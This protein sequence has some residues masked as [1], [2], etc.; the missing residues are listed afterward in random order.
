MFYADDYE[1]QTYTK[2]EIIANLKT[3]AVG[4]DSIQ[5]FENNPQVK[6]KLSEDREQTEASMK[7]IY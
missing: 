2:E 3:S 1:F 6:V 7:K 4:L 5:Y